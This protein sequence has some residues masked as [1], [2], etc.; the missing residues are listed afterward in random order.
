[1]EI[2]E[3]P[4]EILKILIDLQS[5]ETRATALQ[6]EIEQ[7]PQEISRNKEELATYALHLETAEKEASEAKKNRRSLEGDV[8][9]L[10]QKVSNFKTQLMSVKTNVAYQAMLHEIS[11]V[12]EQIAGKEDAILEF[13]LDSDRL[14]DEVRDVEKIFKEK[15]HEYASRKAELE[16]RVEKDIK[17]LEELG[18]RRIELENAL[19]PDQISRYRRVASARHG[20][21][22]APLS[23]DNCSAC[24]VRLRPQLIAEVKSGKNIIQCENCSR[25]LISG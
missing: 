10:R 4:E 24:H 1:M 17:E 5:L 11:F 8:E 23:G 20:Q 6:K 2:Q 12:E 14:A 9:S 18:I 15:E 25:I 21:A 16:S 13:M 3:N 19:P 22:I 7:I